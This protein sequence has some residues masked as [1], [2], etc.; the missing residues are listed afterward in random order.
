MSH[1]KKPQLKRVKCPSGKPGFLGTGPP[2]WARKPESQ[3]RTAISE[4][5]WAGE[6]KEG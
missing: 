1:M 2:T 5:R 6:E 3:A 4:V